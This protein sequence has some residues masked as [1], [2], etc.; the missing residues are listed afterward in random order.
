MLK[1]R[2]F[3]D[4]NVIL[5]SFRT[6]GWTAICNKYSIETVEKCIEEVL[7]GNPNS[8]NHTPVQQKILTGGLTALHKVSKRN[9]ANLV[10][11]H[12]ECQGLDDGELHLFAWAYAQNI[13]PN[14]HIFISTADKAAIRA[15]S[16]L[17][18]INS[19]ISLEEL[20][21]QSGVTSSQIGNLRAH[22]RTSWLSNIKSDILL[23]EIMC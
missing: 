12:P 19:L 17:G 14:Q 3:L 23:D 18:W 7:T 1:S 6:R 11:S 22:Y 13:L 10:L 5:E 21:Q 2:V 20:L 4:T 16:M 9:I 15:T 8:Q